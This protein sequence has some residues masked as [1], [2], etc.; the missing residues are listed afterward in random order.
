MKNAYLW[1]EE[2]SKE[3]LHLIGD[4]P[5]RQTDYL[6]TESW[7]LLVRTALSKTLAGPDYKLITTPDN[8][9]S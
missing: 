9:A 8:P 1:Y 2:L 6:E 4:L 3:I 5:T 7:E